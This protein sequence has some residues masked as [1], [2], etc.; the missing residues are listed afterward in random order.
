MDKLKARIT[1]TEPMLG[2]TAGDSD[3]VRK[4]IA[5]KVKDSKSPTIDKD[6]NA[7]EEVDVVEK[8]LAERTADE[9]ENAMTI[10]PTDD[11]K[12]F[13]WDY[14]V[15]G[16]LKAAVL[17]LCIDSGAYTKE[18]LKKLTLTR[19]TYKRTVDN[20]WF[21]APRRIILNLSGPLTVIQRPLRA[22][23]LRGERICLAISEAAPA[24]TTFD[25]EIKYINPVHENIIR[26][27]LDYGELKGLLQWR[28]A[29]WGRFTW[30]ELHN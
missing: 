26:A 27:C 16:F 5:A 8:T 2:T 28:N 7:T 4:F 3:I 10:Y 13:I 23:T 19:Y 25:C 1:L 9:I 11:G 24:G 15:K 21:P 22:E 17:A 6:A 30:K 18:Q 14:Q 29:G 12:P 20:L